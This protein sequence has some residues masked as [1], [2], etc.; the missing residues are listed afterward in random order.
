MVTFASGE[1]LEFNYQACV[2]TSIVWKNALGAAPETLATYTYDGAAQRLITAATRATTTTSY[3]QYT[4]LP[5]GGLQQLTALPDGGPSSNLSVAARKTRINQ[6]TCDDPP[7]SGTVIH[8]DQLF[9][10]ATPSK[11]TRVGWLPGGPGTVAPDTASANT[12]TCMALS[13]TFTTRIV[14]Q[15][16]SGNPYVAGT[17]VTHKYTTVAPATQVRHELALLSDELSCVM[18]DGGPSGGGCVNQD[19]VK[20]YDMLGSA[21]GMMCSSTNVATGTSFARPFGG[22][23]STSGA[24]G[25]LGA[26]Y[27]TQ[28]RVG[29]TA[30][31]ANSLQSVNFA[32][33]VLTGAP[34][35][36]APV[37][38]PGG[39]TGTSVVDGSAIWSTPTYDATGFVTQV[40]KRGVTANLTA[41]IAQVQLTKFSKSRTCDSPT[42]DPHGRVLRIEGP[43]WE[44]SS[45]VCQ[46][47]TSA[48][49]YIP[50]T[51]FHYYASTETIGNRAGRLRKIV[52]YPLYNG[53]SC[54][55]SLTTEFLEYS[56][57]GSPTKLTDEAG[58]TILYTYRGS[59]ML[60][61]RLG[62]TGPE[63]FFR[64]TSNGELTRI[65]YPDNTHEDWCW[66]SGTNNTCD[67][68]APLRRPR[69]HSSGDIGTPNYRHTRFEYD[70][71]GNLKRAGHTGPDYTNQLVTAWG[72]DYDGRLTWMGQGANLSTSFAEKRAY[73]GNGN[74]AKIGL[75]GSNAPDFCAGPTG[76]YL[77]TAF[78]YDRAD[79]LVSATQNVT[80]TPT[81]PEAV[82]CFDYDK[83][84]NVRRI[85]PGCTASSQ[86]T[87]NSSVGAVSSCVGSSPIDYAVDDFGNVIRVLTPWTNGPSPATTK[88]EYD[89]NGQVIR[90]QTAQ[91]AIE[92]TRLEYNFDGMGRRLSA[93]KDGTGGRVVLFATLY[94]L[95]PGTLPACASSTP[96][97]YLGGRLAYRVDTS[98]FVAYS[99]TIDGQ[100]ER[101]IRWPYSGTAFCTNDT[102]YTYN[103]SGRLLS[104]RYPL[105]RT[106]TY[107][108][109]TGEVR[110][111]MVYVTMRIGGAWVTKNII[112]DIV[113]G[114]EGEVKIYKYLTG[115]S[116]WNTVE[117]RRTYSLSG[118]NDCATLTT[119]AFD[120]SYRL[121]ALWVSSGEHFPGVG[122]GDI[123][124]QT[125]S[126]NGDLM[127]Q[128]KTCFTALGQTSAHVQAY[129]YDNLAR[130]T[131]VTG[132]SLPARSSPS[133]AP[134]SNSYSY[135]LR[136][137]RTAETID[138]CAHVMTGQA[139]DLLVGTFAN[140]ASAEC[141]NAN[142]GYARTYDADGRT[143][144]Y[145]ATNPLATNWWK[146]DFGWANTTVYQAGLDSVF[147]S[148][149]VLG[150]NY[151]VQY[152]ALGRRAKRWL[153]TNQYDL[154][155]YE[156]SDNRILSNVFTSAGVGSSLSA[157]DYIWLGSR[158]VAMIRTSTSD[159]STVIS[160]DAASC[161]RM[162]GPGKCGLYF[163][164]S[165]ILPKP[166]MMI[167]G[168]TGLVT[169]AALYDAF[170]A[171]NRIPLPSRTATGTGPNLQVSLPSNVTSVIDARVLY[172]HYDLPPGVS[173]LVN[174]SAAVTGQ[175]KSH[176][177]SPWVAGAGAT[178]TVSQSGAITA[179]YL[180][181][182][183]E[184]LEYRRRS[185]GAPNM[186]TPI[187]FPGQFYDWEME[188]SDNWNRTYD[189]SSGQYL[190][191]EPLLQSPAYVRR[192]AQ[193]GLSVPTYAYALNNPLRYTDPTGKNPA[194]LAPAAGAVLAGGLLVYYL[195]KNVLAHPPLIG[196]IPDPGRPSTTTF[197][198]PPANPGAGAGAAA[199]AAAAG[200][201]ICMQAAKISCTK[202][203]NDVEEK[204]HQD[205]TDKFPVGSKEWQEAAQS[206]IDMAQEAYRDCVKAGGLP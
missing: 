149:T 66:N 85:L 82:T 113:W 182:E 180:G 27:T 138:G 63:T 135:N 46:A 163:I 195:V 84:G 73:N 45:G 171:V 145:A 118:T 33:P 172:Q 23:D 53:S 176:V 36:Q 122:S 4:M 137:M 153:P 120:S 204:C 56:P 10:P 97:N 72:H 132:T 9:S 18:S 109:D 155:F 101:E 69:F 143:K 94:D 95:R 47:A 50:L 99:Y 38:F 96:T 92:G 201:L 197:P 194:V 159:L 205:W 80:G 104:V 154:Y 189:S 202:V 24:V 71:A 14:S 11:V 57:E 2:V 144:S 114:P 102:Q 103:A 190:S 166:V 44:A 174:G 34:P 164:I 106:V 43:C 200:A 203:R 196:P 62:T 130:L 61:R 98:G 169:N 42:T 12:S 32:A 37:S 126:W 51:E 165:D 124:K 116:N 177:W 160:D 175:Q 29:E 81:G 60:S 158:P 21:T 93:Y 181:F 76:L 111:S 67:P 54:G 148:V 16:P 30:P 127:T 117:Y 87:T 7:C 125:Y 183:T 35:M 156:H 147:K 206:C 59:Q 1:R 123:L 15:E 88:L 49:G 17:E 83:D 68:G 161:D 119:D 13:Q 110:P 146:Q 152:D 75:A 167:E 107:G 19:G 39:T 26:I 20:K 173:L 112:K 121:Q 168:A 188:F 108:Y 186:W 115:T 185:I 40:R 192:M 74:L 170:G 70:E 25:S 91:M 90:K 105:G 5:D 133:A 162:N 52:R 187:R 48:G 31:G 199:G 41:N 8:S 128:Q 22:V 178:V 179:G 150:S 141:L 151:T 142:H 198:S 191:P 6:P 79:R 28:S 193:T 157:D 64:Y 3:L 78:A 129:S 140:P 100:I 89:A 131:G 136:S 55:R 134:Q 139:T 58:A 65:D 184:A 77:C 86:C